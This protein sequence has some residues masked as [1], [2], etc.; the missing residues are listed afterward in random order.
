MEG[1]SPWRIFAR[2]PGVEPESDRGSDPG[3]DRRRGRG[4]FHVDGVHLNLPGPASG[5]FSERHQHSWTT[6]HWPERSSAPHNTST[7]H[8]LLPL[9]LAPHHKEAGTLHAGV[10]SGTGHPNVTHWAGRRPPRPIEGTVRRAWRDRRGLRYRSRWPMRDGR[11]RT[12]SPTQ[13]LPTRSWPSAPS[14]DSVKSAPVPASRS[15]QQVAQKIHAATHPDSQRAHDL[16]DVQLLWHAGTDGGQDLDLPLL[17]QM[18]R[19]T[20]DYRHTHAWP[21]AV[22]L[23]EL[24]DPAYQT[25]REGWPGRR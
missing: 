24:L 11:H 17:V 4:V 14:S 12:P 19:R 5:R 7:S 20:F 10:V 15:E 21:P 22:A 23:P 9:G 3:V 16:V 18:C 2:R 1:D 8:P 25:A 6:A 13:K